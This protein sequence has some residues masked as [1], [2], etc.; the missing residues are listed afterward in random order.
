MILANPPFSGGGHR[1]IQQNF[2]IKTGRDSLP[3]YGR[4]LINS[5]TIPSVGVEHS[6][7]ALFFR[8]VRMFCHLSPKKPVS[9]P[10][11]VDA[12]SELSVNASCFGLIRRYRARI[13][14]WHPFDGQICQKGNQPDYDDQCALIHAGCLP[15]NAAQATSFQI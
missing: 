15:I 7:N 13:S 12:L 1:E 3:V 9:Y 6:L 10:F 11:V 14:R 2:Q 8:H 4:P 5:A